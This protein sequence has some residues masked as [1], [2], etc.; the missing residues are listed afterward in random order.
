M[1]IHLP[2]RKSRVVRRVLFSAVALG[3]VIGGVV[4]G[5]AL[6]QPP[7]KTVKTTGTLHFQ[8][9][10]IISSNL[11]FS[12]GPIRV[13]S[14]DTVTWV[15]HDRTEEPHTVTIV[16]EADLPQTIEDLFAPP[17]PA[18][19][20]AFEG[21][22]PNGA[23]VPVLD[24]GEAGLDGVGDSLLLFPG[25]TIS[26]EVSAAPGETLSYMCIIHPWMQGEITVTG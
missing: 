21:H 8:P 19:I 10:A 5:S 2:S 4:G 24:A 22:F 23:P 15:H 12:P 16:D 26:S 6:A 3:L 14:G 25:G 17:P 11:Q 7:D 20:D 9:N 18:V 1:V 13:A